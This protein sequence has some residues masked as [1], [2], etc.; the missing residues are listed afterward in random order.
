MDKFPFCMGLFSISVWGRSELD[1]KKFDPVV[2]GCS[3]LDTK[4]FDP[5][6]QSQ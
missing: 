1:D 3:V 4:K 6:P 2:W 5:V